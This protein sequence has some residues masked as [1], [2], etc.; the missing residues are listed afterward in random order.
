MLQ[1]SATILGRLQ[2]TAMTVW[3][4]L[5][6]ALIAVERSDPQRAARLLG[7]TD[8]VIERTGASIPPIFDEVSARGRSRTLDQLGPDAFGEAREQGRQLPLHIVTAPT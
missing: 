5:L 6:L 4:L 8:A 2:S 7:A 1:E 3:V